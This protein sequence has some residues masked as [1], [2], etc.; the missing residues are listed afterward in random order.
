MNFPFRSAIQKQSS[1]VPSVSITPLVF[2]HA[3][4][5]IDHK[6]LQTSNYA[7][8]AYDRGMTGESSERPSLPILPLRSLL[9]QSKS[10]MAMERAGATIKPTSDGA[11]VNGAKPEM[12]MGPMASVWTGDAD[13]EGQKKRH[14]AKVSVLLLP[15]C[16]SL[17]AV[18]I[19]DSC[20]FI[21]C[22]LG[23]PPLS[24]CCSRRSPPSLLTCFPS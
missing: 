3:L 12:E 15:H 13:L 11:S 17:Y 5:V 8:S 10:C 19:D 23:S 21:W 22:P 1:N 18:E 2:Q 14:L 7:P 24:F 20:C 16:E 9:S 4:A 6:C